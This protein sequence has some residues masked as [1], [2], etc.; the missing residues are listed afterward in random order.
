MCT[1]FVVSILGCFSRGPNP[2]PPDA[3]TP[4]G[5]DLRPP[6]ETRS[7]NAPDQT[8]ASED[9]TRAP[10]PAA[11]S[12]FSIE[13]VAEGL[14]IPWSIEFLPD[15]RILVSE[16][17]GQL[18]IVDDGELGAPIGGLPEVE[19]RGQGGLLDLALDPDFEDNRWVY[20]SFAEPRGGSGN[21]TSVGRG[22]LADDERSLQDVEIVFRQQPAWDSRLHFGSRLVFAPD[23][24][25]FVTLGERGNAEP[26][27]LA[28]DPTN[29]L[30]SIV[31]IHPDGTV[32]DDNPFVGDAERRPE[33]WS[34]GHRNLQAAT[35]DGE[36]QLWT[37][38]HGPQGGDEL[39]RPEPGKNYGWPVITYGENYNGQPIG[40]GITSRA[41]LE[42]PV[43]YWDPVIAPSGMDFYDGDR[44]ASWKGDLLVGGLQAQAVVRLSMKDG[45]VYTEEWLDIGARVRD[46][47]VGPDGAVHVATDEGTILRLVPS[48]S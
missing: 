2:T 46:V 35:L 29:H 5:R 16:R 34:F 47:K 9:Q 15:G 13:Q 4:P 14:G 7:P 22:R 45:R 42:Q 30:G 37:V 32:P 1:L 10:Q 31:R 41:G 12:R 19:A 21:G 24:T 20:F 44:F 3:A 6:V 28:Q 25:L 27:Q 38:E 23:G 26:R 17:P 48:A 39:N 11:P 43:Y 18:R 36:G 8:P 33:I 40:E